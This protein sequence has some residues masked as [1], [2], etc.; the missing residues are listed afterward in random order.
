MLKEASIITKKIK[1]YQT[2][3]DISRNKLSKR[4]G[5]NL[6]T[7]T[8]IKSGIISNPRIKTILKATGV[9]NVNINNLIK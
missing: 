8:E 5:I 3:E 2:K 6:R 1:N 4:A 9:L 7:I